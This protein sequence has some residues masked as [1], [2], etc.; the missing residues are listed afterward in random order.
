V[1][2]RRNRIKFTFIYLQRFL[3]RFI[4]KRVKQG[5]QLLLDLLPIS[6][7]HKFGSP[8][9]KKPVTGKKFLILPEG[10]LID[11]YKVLYA[12]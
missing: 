9:E 7:M 3:G 10:K 2:R 12:D 8:A 1:V 6:V 4:Q 11:I 5:N